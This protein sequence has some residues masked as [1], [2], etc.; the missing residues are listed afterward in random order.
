MSLSTSIRQVSGIQFDA[1]FTARKMTGEKLNAGIVSL[2][3]TTL[4]RTASQVGKQLELG[5]IQRIRAMGRGRVGDWTYGDGAHTYDLYDAV[6]SWADLEP[7]LREPANILPDF[8]LLPQ[9][10]EIRRLLESEKGVRSCSFQR[11]SSGN[12]EHYTFDHSLK[13][14][15]L[16]TAAMLVLQMD[17]L[18]REQHFP[19]GRM[20]LQ[21]E[22]GSL[23]FW[24]SEL[25]NLMM[26]LCGPELS[27][28]EIQ[29]LIR[30]GD[31][32]Q[33]V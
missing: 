15:L 21:W 19:R 5:H 7:L 25:E 20:H 1:L 11:L 23:W 2:V 26:I 31:A 27:A 4:Q 32:F 13:I 18:C 12:W 16:E 10:P 14:L 9:P 30:C 29:L 8:P 24:V 17:V 22:G 33:L 3:M 28:E 6:S